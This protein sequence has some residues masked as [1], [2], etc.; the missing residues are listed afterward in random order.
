MGPAT[1]FQKVFKYR[2]LNLDVFKVLRVSTVIAL[3]SGSEVVWCTRDLNYLG[4]EVVGCTRELHYL[5]LSCWV[6][7]GS[8]LSGL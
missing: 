3:V 5:D 7:K 2:V 8:E 4:L 6:Y 1:V